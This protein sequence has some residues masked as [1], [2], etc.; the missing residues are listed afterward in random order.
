MDTYIKSA[1]HILE[2]FYNFSCPL[3]SIELK[4]EKDLFAKIPIKLKQ[5]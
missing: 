1:Q 5:T 2:I 4:K 3:Y